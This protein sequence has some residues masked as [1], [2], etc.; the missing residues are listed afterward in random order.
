MDKYKRFK[1]KQAEVL[2]RQRQEEI[3]NQPREI[4][5][6]IQFILKQVT[7]R[8]FSNDFY[9]PQ[10]HG[11]LSMTEDAANS[12]NLKY[13]TCRELRYIW[14]HFRPIKRELKKYGIKV[15]RYHDF[16]HYEVP[17]IFEIGGSAHVIE[18]KW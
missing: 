10:P 14:K 5:E 15:K 7:D 16:A 1:N 8:A 13:S 4:E 18:I 6:G 11:T 12:A 17:S 3:D 2:K 9:T